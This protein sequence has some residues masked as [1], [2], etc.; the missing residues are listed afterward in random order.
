[1]DLIVLIALA[2][3]V[4][5]RLW[6]ILGTKTGV[7]RKRTLILDDSDN[8]IVMTKKQHDDNSTDVQE[9]ESELPAHQNRLVEEIVK[10]DPDFDVE[11]FLKGAEAAYS[12][13]TKAFA[14]GNKKRLKMLLSDDM[15][16]LFSG[17][18]T[19]REK[20]QLTIE[21]KI[22]SFEIV[23]IDAAKV[24]DVK[25]QKKAQITV[26]FKTKQVV[27]TYDQNEEIVENEA[28]TSI[29]RQD[30]WTFERAFNADSLQWTLVNT[31]TR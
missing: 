20:D 5:Y 6:S 12:M 24:I 27:V 22:E 16:K 11:Y 3:F 8:V 15:Y 29:L 19:T 7:E 17:S 30:Y 10:N 13:I 25:D 4:L 9:E 23:E 26:F 18:I 1:M 28:K 14:K 21:T 2:C 31:K